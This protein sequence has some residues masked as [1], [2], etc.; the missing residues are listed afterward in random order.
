VGEYGSAVL[1]GFQVV[2]Q[3]DEIITV[4][5]PTDAIRPSGSTTGELVARTPWTL[6]GTLDHST[7]SRERPVDAGVGHHERMPLDG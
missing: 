5:G 4:W 7:V 6:V 1:A 2:P 3:S